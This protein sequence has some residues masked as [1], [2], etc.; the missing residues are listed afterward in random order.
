MGNNALAYEK[1]MQKYLT[2]PS[3][4]EGTF[5]DVQEGSEIVFEEADEL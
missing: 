2:V 5:D 4:V 3:M 1:R